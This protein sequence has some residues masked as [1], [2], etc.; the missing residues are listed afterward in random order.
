MSLFDI[1]L[2]LYLAVQKSTSK[3]VCFSR[4]K[5]KKCIANMILE[6]PPVKPTA[7]L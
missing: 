6:N 5:R 3:F 7:S 1:G 4:E 2:I